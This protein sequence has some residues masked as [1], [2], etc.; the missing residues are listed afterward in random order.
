MET[1]PFGAVKPAGPELLRRIT[2]PAAME[3]A[4]F[5][6]VKGHVGRGALLDTGHGAAMETAPFGAVKDESSGLPGA[7][8]TAAMETA[9]FG[10]VKQTVEIGVEHGKRAAMETAP[11][12]AVKSAM[13]GFRWPDPNCRN[14][15]RSFRSGEGSP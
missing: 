1:A 12:G 8:Q 10:A 4:P 9:P 3:T 2:H 11:F 15:D 14:G 13:T 6:A 5:G 7:I